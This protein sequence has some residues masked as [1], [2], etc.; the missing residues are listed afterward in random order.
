MNRPWL[1]TLNVVCSACLV[2]L[3]AVHGLGNSLQLLDIGALVPPA[4]GYLLLAVAVCHFVLGCVLTFETLREQKRA[5]AAY[6]ALNK[7]F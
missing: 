2:V 3:L 6:W 5:G 4:V 7:R 1:K